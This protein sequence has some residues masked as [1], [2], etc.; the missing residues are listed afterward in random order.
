MNY[1]SAWSPKDFTALATSLGMQVQFAQKASTWM[2]EA[3]R[4]SGKINPQQLD[5]TWDIENMAT[6]SN[7]RHSYIPSIS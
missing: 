3:I 2:S 4:K 1:K 6:I 7:A 5:E